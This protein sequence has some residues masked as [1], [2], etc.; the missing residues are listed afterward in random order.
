MIKQTTSPRHHQMWIAPQAYRHEQEEQGSYT[1]TKTW[2]CKCQ[3]LASKECF[4]EHPYA[5]ECIWQ[6]IY[7]GLAKKSQVRSICVQV[8]QT[9]SRSSCSLVKTRYL[10]RRYLL[11]SILVAPAFNLI[12][13]ACKSETR[14]FR[15]LIN[16]SRIYISQQ[17][18]T[19]TTLA[20]KQNRRKSQQHES[21]RIFHRRYS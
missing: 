1:S 20:R 17:K 7:S 11:K 14:T 4:V 13:D 15:V 12:L 21:S 10:Q 16:R 3:W 8:L 9:I 6:H 2:T 5:N 19:N 18:Y